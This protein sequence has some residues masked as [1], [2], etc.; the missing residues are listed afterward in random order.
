MKLIEANGIIEM[1][2]NHINNDLPTPIYR[3]DLKESLIF[4]QV[5]AEL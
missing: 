1:A 3:Q 4:C 5:L 2:K